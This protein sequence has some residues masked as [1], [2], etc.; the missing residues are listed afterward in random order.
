MKP[1]IVKKPL[2]LLDYD[3]T[4]APLVLN[5]A[6]AYPHPEVPRLLL[7]LTS[8]YPLYIVTGRRVQDLEILLPVPSLKVVGV[9][10][11]EERTVGEELK[12]QKISER[13]LVS[14]N[15]LRKN[16]PKV[17]GLRVEDKGMTIALH[18]RGVLDEADVEETLRAWILDIPEELEALWGKKVLEVRPIGFGKGKS[19]LQLAAR[20]TE[21]IYWYFIKQFIN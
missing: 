16:L 5:P 18:Y 3:G 20:H 10:G 2:I 7:A 1:L 13:A 9:H 14:L 17:T 4:L 19:V 11:L 15:L 21:C 6:L 8:R 12:S